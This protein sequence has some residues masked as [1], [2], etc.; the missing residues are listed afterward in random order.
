MTPITGI[1]A[2]DAANYAAWGA[3]ATPPGSNPRGYNGVV[4]QINQLAGAEAWWD[5]T[6]QTVPASQK[7]GLLFWCPAG[8]VFNIC[9]GQ[10]PIDFATSLEL[11]FP[12]FQLII[13][14]AAA[15]GWPVGIACRPADNYDAASGNRF[16]GT[17]QN[18][19]DWLTHQG[20]RCRKILG[21]NAFY[22]GDSLT[23]DLSSLPA[24]E[25]FKRAVGPDALLLP[26]CSGCTQA[27]VAALLQVGGGVYGEMKDAAGNLYWENEIEV[28]ALKAQFPS[29]V[30]AVKDASGATTTSAV[31]RSFGYV[32]IVEDWP[33]GAAL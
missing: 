1:I 13:D 11:A 15:R 20:R 6:A 8:D 18:H 16:N 23:N 22:Y 28:A 29:A 4:R 30:W 24:L 32:P 17:N 3:T 25:V 2:F 7:P 33:G 10:W 12:G 9:G 5:A 19:V 31:K 26:E 14:E 27:Q 21:D